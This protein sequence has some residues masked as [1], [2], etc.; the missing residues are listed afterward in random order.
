MRIL[1]NIDPP[2]FP[3]LSEPLLDLPTVIPGSFPNTNVQIVSDNL[4]TVPIGGAQLPSVF[5]AQIQNLGPVEDTFALTFPPS[6]IPA[7]FTI[8]SSVPEITLPPGVTGEIGVCLIPENGLPASGTPA[9]FGVEV[10]STTDSSVNATDTEPFTIPDVSGIT[11]STDPV[12]FATTPGET[13]ASTLTI[14]AVGNVDPDTATITVEAPADLTVSGLTSPVTVSGTTTQALTL[15]SAANTPPNS[16]LTA[17]ITATFGSADPPFTSTSF[18]TVNVVA[19]QSIPVAE[20]AACLSELGQA[21]TAAS[22]ETISTTI[23]SLLGDLDNEAFKSRLLVNVD[24]L[25][26]QLQNDPRFASFV[27]ALNA[28][29][30]A[31]ATAS[32]PTALTSAIDNLSS[33][34]GQLNTACRNVAS[35]NFV[36]S[37]V[38]SSVELGP[39][40]SSVLTLR[41]ESLGLDP[42]PLTL[43]VGTLPTG[44]TGTLNASS[45]T[46]NPGEVRDGTSAQPITL[47]LD[48]T[49]TDTAVFPVQVTATTAGGEVT[50]TATAHVA[51]H[52]TVADVLSVT[53]D[54]VIVMA[55]GDP[56]SGSAQILNTAN[57]ERSVLARVEVL[58][59]TGT[60][61]GGPVDLPVELGVSANPV[62]L[63]LGAIA[64]G[65]L[66]EGRHSL[67]VSLTDASGVALSGRSAEAPFYV[68]TP[69]SATVSSSATV[70]PPGNSTVSATI[71]VRNLTA[72]QGGSSVQ[73]EM[74]AYHTAQAVDL[75]TSNL[76]ESVGDP[77]HVL[78]VADGQTLK[79]GGLGTVIV[80]LGPGSHQAV[81]GPGDDLMVVDPGSSPPYTVEVSQDGVQYVP[82]AQVGSGSTLFDLAGSGL[83]EVRFVKIADRDDATNPVEVDAVL[84]LNAKGG[85]Q[86]ERVDFSVGVEGYSQRTGTDVGIAS[87]PIVGNVDADPNPEIV[88]FTNQHAD[89]TLERLVVVDGA[90]GALEWEVST[91]DTLPD[92][93][94]ALGDIHPG[95]PGPEI[96]LPNTKRELRLLSSTGTEVWNVPGGGWSSAIDPVLANLDGDS[97]PEILSLTSTLNYLTVFDTDGLVAWNTNFGLL[98]YA[99]AADVNSDG[100]TDVIA[101]NA[102]AASVLRAYQAPAVTGPTADG[103]LLWETVLGERLD[104][105]FAIADVDG[106]VGGDADPEIVIG[107]SDGLL[108]LVNHDGTILKKIDMGNFQIGSPAIADINNDGVTDIVVTS[109][110]SGGQIHALSLTA[111]ALALPDETIPLADVLLWAAP[112]IDETFAQGITVFDLDGNGIGEV[113]WN[114]WGNS[115][116][117]ANGGLRILSG[118]DGAML[119]HNARING[120]SF[121]G[122]PVV[123][124]VDGDGHVEIVTGDQE[125]LWIIGADGMWIPSRD[126]W[127]QDSYHITNINDD[128][129]VPANE[130]PAWT[131]HNTFHAQRP[132]TGLLNRFRVETQHLLPSSGYL[133]NPASVTPPADSLTA[134]DIV[135]TTEHDFFD[136]GVRQFLVS[137]DV[138]D[139]A[140]GEHRDISLGSNVTVTTTLGGVPQT[141]DL[142]LPSLSVAA[143][144]I[145]GMDP[146]GQTVM[147]GGQVTYLVDVTNPSGT[148]TLQLET[149]GL[150]GVAVTFD[151][152]GPIDPGQSVRTAMTVAVPFGTPSGSR[153]FS[154][155]AISGSEVLDQ[156]RG[157]LVIT[158]MPAP[159]DLT[160][161]PNSQ[162][163]L[164]GTPSTFNLFL[165]HT[166]SQ[167]TTYNLA[168]S[169]LPSG[170]T[171]MVSPSLVTLAPGEML[172]PDNLSLGPQ[173]TLTQSGTSLQ[174]F[175]FTVSVSV[176]G[177][178]EIMSSVQGTVTTKPELV[179]VLDVQSDPGFAQAGDP[180][181]VSTRIINAVNHPRTVQVSYVVKDPS[182][183]EVF[184][185]SPVPATLTLSS[186]LDTV[187]LG[188]LDTTGFSNGTHT[189]EVTVVDAANPTQPVG[190]GQG[191]LLIGLPLTAALTLSPEVL[192]PGDGTVTATLQVESVAPPPSPQLSLLGLVD[193]PGAGTSVAFHGSVAY[194]CGTEDVAIVDVNDPTA[195]QILSTFAENDIVDSY[196]TQCRIIDNHLVV[197]WQ[198]L[199]NADALPVLVYDLADPLNPSLHHSTTL[200][201]RFINNMFVK[202]HTAFLTSLTLSFFGSIL[203]GQNG[204]FFAVDFSQLDNPQMAD[205]LLERYAEPNGGDFN[206]FQAALVADQYAYVATT[207]ETGDATPEGTGRV[208]VADVADPD[209]ITLVTELALPGTVYATGIGHQGPLALAVGNTGPR[210]SIRQA[211]ALFPFT[212]TLKLF[213]LD[214]SDPTNPQILGEL[215]TTLEYPG[216]TH[217]TPLGHGFFAVGGANDQ[218]TEVLMIVDV[219]DPQNLQFTTINVTGRVQESHVIGN[220]L[221]TVSDSGLAIYDI[222][223]VVGTRVT[224]QVRI[225]T[226]TDVAP[227][228]GS[229]SIPP[230]DILVGQDFDTLVWSRSLNDTHP[231]DTITWDLSVNNLQIGEVRE[232]I[233][234]ATIDFMVPDEGEGQI[235]LPPLFVASEQLLGLD[236]GSQTVR[237]GEVASYTVGINNPTDT[238]VSYDLQVQG[239]PGGWV[240]LEPNVTIGSQDSTSLTLV[241]QADPA[242]GVGDYPFVVSLHDPV[243]KASRATIQGTLHLVGD[244]VI[245]PARE[246]RGVVVSLV[247][248]TSTAGQGTSAAYTVRLTN[249][250]NVTDTYALAGIFPAGV[251]G[252][253]SQ[254]TVDVPAGLTNYRDVVLTLTPGLGTPPGAL[255]FTVTGT[256]TTAGTVQSQ[257][258]G[259]LTVVDI[260]VQVA[261]S[262]LAGAPDSAYTLTVTNTSGST[263]P[264]QSFTVTLAGPLAS[265]GTMGDTMVTLAS[266]AS[267]AIPITLDLQGLFFP[268]PVPLIGVATSVANPAVLASAQAT[269]TVP[270]IEGLT[271]T[272]DPSER[273]VAAVDDLASFL[274]LVRNSGNQE[275]AY[276]AEIIGMSGPLSAYLVGLDGQPTN[277]IP[278]FRLPGLATG[279][280]GLRASLSAIG[281]GTVT[282]RVTS[283]GENGGPLAASDIATVLLPNQAPIA[284]AGPDLS[285]SLGDTATLD[286]SASSDPDNF[287]SALTFE[288][289]LITKPNDSGLTDSDL[290]TPT[291]P[292]ATL[293]PDVLGEYVVQL[294]VSDGEESGLDEAVIRAENQVPVAN[295][296]SDLNVATGSSVELDGSASFDGDGEMITYQWT[297]VAAPGTSTRTSADIIGA[298]TPNPSFLPDVDGSYTLQLVVSDGV[299]PSEPD[300]VVLVATSGN[301]P[302]NADAGVGQTVSLGS[303]VFLNA[304]ASADPDN[305]PG[306]L[307]FQWSFIEVP[308]VSGLLNGNIQDSSQAQASFVPDTVGTYVLQVAVSD[309]AAS[310]DAQV[311]ILVTESNV[312][313]IADAGSD[314]SVP[315]GTEVT[316]DGSASTDPDNGPENA[317]FVWELV[318]VPELSGLHNA[319]ILDDTTSTPRFT[320]DVLGTYVFRLTVSDG[321]DTVS[322]NV[323]VS[324]VEPDVVV[325]VID[326]DSLGKDQDPNQFSSSQVNEDNADI[327]VRT[328]LPVFAANIGQTFTLYTGEVGDE[329]WFALKTIPSSWGSTGP[330]ADGLR[331]FVGNPSMASPHNVGPGLGSGN[332]PEDLLDEIPNVTPLRATGLKQLEGSRVCAVVYKS[333]ISMNYDP[334]EGSLKGDNVGTVAFE[335]LSVTQRTNGS[336]SSLPEV[337]IK[338][339]DAETVCEGPLSLFTDAPVPTSSSEPFDV[340]P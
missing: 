162:V 240:T 150:D 303:S 55:V 282:V 11:L 279:A 293:T 112:A 230:T 104:A 13:V 149:V 250:G 102:S 7:G 227:V 287:P 23:T 257:A 137:G 67:R 276:S 339:L 241:V 142:P 93:T 14:N 71:E 153:V 183:T 332:D 32:D 107:T 286:G 306:A 317:T 218:G 155:V 232:V 200:N 51:V 327:G 4:F 196:N 247:P 300:E 45:L 337:E 168:V 340:V 226:N 132:P 197:F 324:V 188:S 273:T 34:L 177:R 121:R 37:F 69:V 148:E 92:Y 322:D 256:S 12:S 8:Q 252:L 198:I 314:Q 160:L 90:T 192:P 17:T 60:V 66:T 147:P 313:P 22:M 266:G 139:L 176:Q 309:G 217:V 330:T 315:L 120:K 298:T 167:T 224:S 271:A 204:D 26:A 244:P 117:L 305:G 323:M 122:I 325:L 156:V 114:G 130:V 275:E 89:T 191:T 21:D 41:L 136:A 220:R 223:D 127:N 98:K 263:Q 255:P 146:A 42:T 109:G 249:T 206:M 234:G 182:A 338:I 113:I 79:L 70:L 245:A 103:L 105:A 189:I 310:D 277:K 259:V 242:T 235:E 63:E 261:L 333:D 95:S 1:N 179:S 278:S 231:I 334:L 30:M 27:A 43:T 9:S 195:P 49:L 301:V 44:V 184:T 31:L 145:L 331:N 118:L 18:V 128:L 319:L 272:M 2:V 295:A 326:E 20:G 119:Y 3:F 52:P 115:V 171:A 248:P 134:T 328:P 82:L 281:E 174:E 205:A 181:Q 86:V 214:V 311:S 138:P 151:P 124:D 186:S 297:L 101:A 46:L 289:I 269:V 75:N 76:F 165:H 274:L 10:T 36:P 39:G 329:G 221:H 216:K 193:T 233:Q 296:G 64:T 180:V 144:H 209:D 254:P 202:D 161:I 268:G 264:P 225:P 166:G 170:V 57:A 267:Q 129:T 81:D 72:P 116:S 84:V 239:I 173:V 288:W 169:G 229:F 187:D 54:P 185:S 125:G 291:D 236:P 135:W 203:T 126:I 219:N 50:K 83:S 265:F 96:V 243:T 258:A 190:I 312:P 270:T 163:A 237:P 210:T 290:G 283:L 47:T 62:D 100:K 302:P 284:D 29:R 108:N 164:P 320:P 33:T 85:I 94:V 212:G 292:T 77:N 159:V 304:T 123:A 110:L 87:T 307:T 53:A 97:D 335:V 215:M 5:R 207:T 40:E 175:G 280:I 131:A 111:A 15:T 68:G 172:P 318:S 211:D 246:T 201:R 91:E 157:E 99:L 65:G 294:T 336:S 199:L 35:F 80:D 178:P 88:L 74:V 253:F 238:E 24:S 213:S 106:A 59:A 141:F 228:P 78:G 48:Q 194:V 308:V 143:A 299:A 133:V 73:Q 58:N 25:I 38:P 158:T 262:P 28:D 152:T 16:R 260:G 61:V 321:E 285:L 251:T 154:V 56:L 140:P 208:M 222:G 19:P 6:Q 316:L